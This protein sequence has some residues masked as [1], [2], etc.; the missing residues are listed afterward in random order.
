MKKLTI[1]NKELLDVLT[2]WSDWFNTYDLKSNVTFEG[3]LDP[4]EWYTSKEYLES[5]NP[6]THS[7]YGGTHSYGA[8]L[9]NYDHTTSDVR[10]YGRAID[11]ALGPILSTN[12]SAVKMYYP[13][14]GYMHWH[15]NHNVS[16]YN[17]LLTYTK[18]GQGWFKYRD[19]KTRQ[20]ITMHDEPG[21]TAK[22]GYYGSN[23]ELD[24]IYWHCAR[25]Y[26]DRFT[27]G[28]VIHHEEFWQ[29][30]CDDIEDR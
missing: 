14:G 22:A 25:A 19:P 9:L 27:L 10:K 21:W 16:G 18:N 17:I 20:I 13:E 7:G 1:N 11:E 6:S 4:D 23:A 2:K 8:D 28:Y 30:M 24:R 12:H 15:N 26:E 5:I 3:E 29:M